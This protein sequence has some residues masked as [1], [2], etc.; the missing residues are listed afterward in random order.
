LGSILIVG[1]KISSLNQSIKEKALK[2]LNNPSVNVENQTKIKIYVPYICEDLF[3][4]VVN[5]AVQLARLRLPTNMTVTNDYQHLL[6]S[7]IA[8][9]FHLLLMRN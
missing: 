4:D 8:G 6:S 2:A 7:S 3:A 9:L 5:S 1:N